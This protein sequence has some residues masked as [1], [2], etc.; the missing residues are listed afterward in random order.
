MRALAASLFAMCSRTDAA[1][2]V[3]RALGWN[4]RGMTSSAD[5]PVEAL[6][7]RESMMSA[8]ASS[9]EMAEDAT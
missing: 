7:A 6:G 2:D 1:L 4:R 9:K 3:G 5:V 8:M